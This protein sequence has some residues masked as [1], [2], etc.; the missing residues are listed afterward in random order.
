MIPE[1]REG[2]NVRRDGQLDMVSTVAC[3]VYMYMLA[4]SFVPTCALH[5]HIHTCTLYTMSVYI[6]V[7]VHVYIVCV[8]HVYI[9]LVH[10]LTAVDS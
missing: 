2:G 7:H 9:L 3:A 8:L 10:V 1:E 4:G 5:I 6:H